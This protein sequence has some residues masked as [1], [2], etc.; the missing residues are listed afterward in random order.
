M[1][2]KLIMQYIDRYGSYMTSS[3]IVLR[4]VVCGWVALCV[5]FCWEE[6]LP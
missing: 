5:F 2:Q 4:V 6:D 3:L 1:Q